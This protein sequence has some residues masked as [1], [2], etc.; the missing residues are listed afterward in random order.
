MLRFLTARRIACE[1]SRDVQ[2]VPMGG[3]RSQRNDDGLKTD[4]LRKTRPHLANQFVF[5]DEEE[6]ASDMAGQAVGKV[7]LVLNAT[8]HLPFDRIQR[9]RANIINQRGE[10]FAVIGKQRQVGMRSE[11]SS[12]L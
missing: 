5:G 11:N 3:P 8:G 2:R 12:D 4:D 9:M 1:T 10:D 7:P 6:V